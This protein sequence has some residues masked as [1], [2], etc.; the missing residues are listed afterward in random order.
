MTVVDMVCLADMW[1]NLSSSGDIVQELV[2]PGNLTGRE[3][4]R[5]FKCVLLSTAPK[6]NGEDILDYLHNAV[7]HVDFVE[8]DKES[9]G[10]ESQGEN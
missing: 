5:Y 8:I 1:V 2:L 6:R 10:K 4:D 3:K 7:D 9:W